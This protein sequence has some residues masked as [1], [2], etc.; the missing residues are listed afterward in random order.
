[1]V[2]ALLGIELPGIRSLRDFDRGFPQELF[3]RIA[4]RETEPADGRM[5]D[6]CLGSATGLT[7]A[8]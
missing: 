1:V 4:V 6:R 8:V 2:S 3:D 5:P 7:P